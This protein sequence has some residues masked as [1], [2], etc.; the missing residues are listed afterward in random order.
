VPRLW[1]GAVRLPAKLFPGPTT[2]RLQ[3]EL[4]MFSPY[5]CV[6]GVWLSVAVL[7]DTTLSLQV[8]ESTEVIRI[9][10]RPVVSSELFVI[11]FPVTWLRSPLETLIPSW[12]AWS[13]VL[14]VMTLSDDFLFGWSVV[15][16]DL[17]T[18]MPCPPTFVIVTP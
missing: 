18:W 16:E 14:P 12:P 13:I 4:A 6:L 11:M 10:S 1:M 7:F 17:L 15:G 8:I 2:V 3:S 5:F 9:P